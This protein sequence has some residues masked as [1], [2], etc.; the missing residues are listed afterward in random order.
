[1]SNEQPPYG[2]AQQFIV[3]QMDLLLGRLEQLGQQLRDTVA[4]I[5]GTTVAEAVS[6]AIRL[7][8]KLV[9]HRK[10]SPSG[11]D[12]WRYGESYDPYGD[13]GY[14]QHYQFER[15]AY[16]PAP[17]P[18][19]DWRGIMNRVV[20]LAARTVFRLKSWRFGPWLPLGGTAVLEYLLLSPP[21]ET[22]G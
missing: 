14:D 20:R 17:R 2:P 12:E 11:R 8:M 9:P 7:A 21:A 16:S 10:T 1:M 15:D 13:D 19:W 5:I 3:D 22:A 4:R 18:T 6:E